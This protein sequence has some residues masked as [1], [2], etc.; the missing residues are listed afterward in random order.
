MHCIHVCLVLLFI[1]LPACN[2]TKFVDF[3]IPEGTITFQYPQGWNIEDG[4][5]T[6]L[7]AINPNLHS[8]TGLTNMNAFYIWKHENTAKS[9]LES[10]ALSDRKNYENTVCS[11]PIPTVLNNVGHPGFYMNCEDGT[12]VLYIEVH[13]YL[14]SIS[15]NT[16][17]PY[18][19]IF[20]H[21]KKSIRI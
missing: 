4:T 12:E 15:F 10:Y 14:Y 6:G 21:M 8:E 1:T 19:D 9:S 17:S 5:M 18:A 3:T 13:D 7:Y 11:L 20:T 2:T 16:K